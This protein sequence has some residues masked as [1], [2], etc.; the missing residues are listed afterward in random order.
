MNVIFTLG[1]PGDPGGQ[2][3]ITAHFEQF[4]RRLRTGLH[5]A[6]AQLTDELLARVRGAEPY[7]TGKLRSA[8][9]A[10]V[11]D[12]EDSVR[13]IVTVVSEAGKYN[14]A[15]AALEYGA[16]RITRVRAHQQHLSHLF[17]RAIDARLVSVRGYTRHPNIQ[18][19]RF[20]R[21]PAQAM[22]PRIEAEIQR[23]VAESVKQ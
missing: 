15:A 20:L 6:I 21:D 22:R 3:T 16:H 12:D 13:G 17:D 11:H 14:V 18:A 4:S 8:T 19:V 5:Q 10:F 7:R 9:Q 23:V 2:R 1:G